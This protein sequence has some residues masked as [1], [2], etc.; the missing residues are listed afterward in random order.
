MY[1]YLINRGIEEKRLIQEERSTSTEE[2][3]KF[4]KEICEEEGLGDSVVI[5]TSEFH[6][7]R[8]SQLAEELGFTVYTYGAST[9]LLYFPTYFLREV[10]GVSYFWLRDNFL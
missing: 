6:E 5:I 3:L 4:S 9:N 1:Q 7:Y 2:N 8:A 10:L